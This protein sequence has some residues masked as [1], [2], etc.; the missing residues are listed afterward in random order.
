MVLSSRSL[1]IDA[2][3]GSNPEGNSSIIIREE[4]SVC[5]NQIRMNGMQNL[6]SVMR[7]SIFP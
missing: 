7:T 4:Y 2:K 3:I 1:E 6:E 5:G